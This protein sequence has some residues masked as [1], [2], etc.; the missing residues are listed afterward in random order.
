MAPSAEEFARWR[1]DNVTRWIFRALASNADECRAAW[2]TV[3]WEN[4]QANPLLLIELRTR[5]D[6]LRSMIDSSY[7][8]FCETNGDEPSE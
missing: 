4:G 1:D 8:A 5:A 2:E 7:E 6:A 3:S